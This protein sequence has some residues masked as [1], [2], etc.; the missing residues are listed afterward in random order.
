MIQSLKSR[1]EFLAL[2]NAKSYKS[3][4]FIAQYAPY[5]EVDLQVGM[6]VSKKNG[7]AVKRNLIKRRLKEAL[8][9]LYKTHPKTNLKL[10]FISRRAVA[11]CE[12]EHLLI[13]MKKF[14]QTLP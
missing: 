12:F 3:K 11:D 8:R 7:N 4:F 5:D 13:E 1:K 10:N 2:R 6:T 9:L 14:L